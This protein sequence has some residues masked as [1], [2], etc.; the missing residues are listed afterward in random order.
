MIK[1]LM[2]EVTTLEKNDALNQI[3]DRQAFYARK[4]AFLYEKINDFLDINTIFGSGKLSK[5]L[6]FNGRSLILTYISSTREPTMN[7]AE[8]QKCI[9]MIIRMLND[10]TVLISLKITMIHLLYRKYGELSTMRG[11]ADGGKLQK[12]MIKTLVMIFKDLDV[13]IKIA[14]DELGTF[15][16]EVINMRKSTIKWMNDVEQRDVNFK[17]LFI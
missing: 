16:Q 3:R 12:E 7:E 15:K 13:W 8:L 14:A 1:Y 5:E 11:V 4:N 2:T 17:E 6:Q 9:Y 10:S